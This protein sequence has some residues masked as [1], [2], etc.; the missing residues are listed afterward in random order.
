MELAASK[1]HASDFEEQATIMLIVNWIKTFEYFR[2]CILFFTILRISFFGIRSF[3]CFSCNHVVVAV[4]DGV[5]L[6]GK[7]VHPM[8]Q[9]R[10]P[11]HLNHVLYVLLLAKAF[12]CQIEF[13]VSD[14]T[15][16]YT[17]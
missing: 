3:C 10:D 14:R 12:K 4:L 11:V 17:A 1:A 5:A 8:E 15:S 13:P 7:E 9:T 2:N 16:S 6:S